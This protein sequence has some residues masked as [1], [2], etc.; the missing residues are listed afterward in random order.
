MN[1]HKLDTE[2]ICHSDNRYKYD[3]INITIDMRL[4]AVND[5]KDNSDK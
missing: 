2:Q 1:T 3:S 5:T 4:R